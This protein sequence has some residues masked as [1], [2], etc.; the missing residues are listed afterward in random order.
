MRALEQAPVARDRRREAEERYYRQRITEA[1][2][3]LGRIVFQA[4]DGPILPGDFVMPALDVG[5]PEAQKKGMELLRANLTQA[6]K[7]DWDQCGHFHV[8]GNVTGKTYRIKKGRQMNIFELDGGGSEVQGW[9]FLP[10]GGL[11]EGDV[12]LAQKN[13]LELDEAGALKIANKFGGP[14]ATPEQIADRIRYYEDMLQ[15]EGARAREAVQQARQQQPSVW[16]RILEEMG[17]TS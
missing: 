3:M 5:T 16:Q 9:C 10:Q 14:L 15:G 6:Q 12:L 2:D 4:T 11:V 17:V 13:A 8:V 1:D 7:A